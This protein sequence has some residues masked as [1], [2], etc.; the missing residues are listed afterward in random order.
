MLPG[1][2]GYDIYR[3]NVDGTDVRPLVATS[4]NEGLPAWSP[5]GT[6]LAF[7]SDRGGSWGLW[8]VDATGGN[9]RLLAELPGS[10]DGRVEFEPD[11]LNRGWMEEQ[12]SWSY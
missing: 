7:V 6:A 8:V 9:P 10:I 11:Y 5:D 12:I 4:A 2:G 3:A 1:D